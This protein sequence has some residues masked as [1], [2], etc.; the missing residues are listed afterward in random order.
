MKVSVEQI[1]ASN[2][3]KYDRLIPIINDAF[4]KVNASNL[5]IYIDLYSIFKPLY[6][7]LDI[8]IED[9][10][11]ITSLIINMCAHYKDLFIRSYNTDTK[12]YIVYSENCNSL[13]KQFYPDYNYGAEL[14]I[15]AKK[16]IHDIIM[17]NVKLL[18]ILCPYIHDIFFISGKFETG[19][20]M[21]DIILKNEVKD[22][23]IPNIIITKD[24]YNYQLTN[25]NAY[26]LILKSV[27]NKGQDESYFIKNENI[28]NELI[29]RKKIKYRPSIQ[30]NP[31]LYSFILALSNCPERNIKTLLNLSKALEKMEQSM[32][33]Y[34][35]PNF[36]IFDLES[37]FNAISLLLKNKIAYSTFE[38]RFKAIDI[39]FQ[40]SVFINTPECKSMVFNNFYDP[41]TVTMINNKYFADYP[42]H[43]NQL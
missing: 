9:N 32:K 26:T 3:V 10:M 36:Y 11:L 27:K 5:N 16:R 7:D 4:R 23:N 21:H 35:L 12:F 24:S 42:L 31:K 34:K 30:I 43:L 17:K 18:N 37:A 1:I 40:H 6:S 22:L 33:D 8:E 19:V 13:N 39:V 38:F 20:I 25:S 15:E 41:R 29:K 28:I 14:K 2:Y